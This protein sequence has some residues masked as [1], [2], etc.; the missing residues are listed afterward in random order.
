VIFR[1]PMSDLTPVTGEGENGVGG[2]L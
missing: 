2:Q 1:V